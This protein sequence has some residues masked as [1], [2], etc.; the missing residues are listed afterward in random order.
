VRTDRY[1]LIHYYE[2]DQW[3]LFD[4]E[5]DPQEMRSVYSEPAYADRVAELKNLLEELKEQYEV[6]ASAD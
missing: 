4:L 6:P 5:T 3:E 2:D 1:K